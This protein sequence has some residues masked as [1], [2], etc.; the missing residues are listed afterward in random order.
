MKKILIL[1][2]VLIFP[3]E[4]QAQLFPTAQTSTA[5]QE[6]AQQ[7]QRINI[8]FQY[9]VM[10]YRK[11][12][13]AFWRNPKFTPAQMA[14]AHGTQCLKI[15]QNSA[16]TRNYINSIDPNVLPPNYQEPLLPYTVEM[17]DGEPTGRI[18]IGGQG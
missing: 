8:T 3:I 11:E 5:E 18:I 16:L 10:A 1:L 9:W 12:F 4:A 7:I 13:D 17:E 15:F 14:E 6:A 2:A